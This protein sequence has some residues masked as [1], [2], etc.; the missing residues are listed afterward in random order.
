MLSGR[1][2]GL[3]VVAAHAAPCSTYNAAAGSM[4]VKQ[5]SCQNG[6]HVNAPAC[7]GLV[8]VHCE[9]YEQQGGFRAVHA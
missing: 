9:M 7:E 2:Q 1:R 3:H 5:Q 8:T 4:G 6:S